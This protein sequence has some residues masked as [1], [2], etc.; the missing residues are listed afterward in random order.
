MHNS[1]PNIKI[2]CFPGINF[3]DFVDFPQIHEYQIEMLMLSLSNMNILSKICKD[4]AQLWQL[5]M[6]FKTSEKAH[7][8]TPYKA[9]FKVMP[10]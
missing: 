2:L 7:K 9:T 4:I 5:T 6:N 1:Y 10:N 8:V 3:K